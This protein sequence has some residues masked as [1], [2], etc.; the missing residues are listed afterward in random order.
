M[1]NPICVALIAG[2]VGLTMVYGNLTAGESSHWS[3]SGETGP[4]HWSDLSPDFATCG[5]GVNQ[6]PIDISDTI[7]A[8]LN[9][10]QFNYETDSVDIVNNGHTLQVNARPGNWLRVRG[11]EFQLQQLHFHSPSEHRINGEAFSLEA[12]FVHKDELGNL[13][14]VAVLFHKGEWNA[15][16]EKIGMAGPKTAGQSAP[17]DISFSSLD[18]YRNHETYFRY[19]GSLTTPPCTEGI[20]WYILKEV[21][22]VSPVQAAKFVDLIGDAARGPQPLNARSVLER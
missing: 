3:Y 20:R 4:G 18:L 5:N 8:E 19:S 1:H 15:D 22:S 16:L 13:A 2:A 12:H 10:L 7:A 9:P 11:Q 6:S 17:F 21:R 14:V